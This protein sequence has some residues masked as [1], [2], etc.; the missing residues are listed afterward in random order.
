MQ[1]AGQ[2]DDALLTLRADAAVEAATRAVERL[3]FGHGLLVREELARGQ[4]HLFS[5]IQG[6]DAAVRGLPAENSVFVHHRERAVEFGGIEVLA[7]E[8]AVDHEG[9][10]PALSRGRGDHRGAENHVAGR[11]HVRD[12]RLQGVVVDLDGPRCV[13]GEPEC[14]RVGPH[15]RGDDHQVAGDAAQ[16]AVAVLRGELAPLR[17]RPPRSGGARRPH[18]VFA[19]EPG[20]P[21]EF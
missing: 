19:L 15:A 21:Q 6:I 8:P 10:P 13:D 2:I 4:C 12:A 18:L 3:F 9:G 11:E 7:L 16:R 1:S 5:G 20:I 17:R 14:A